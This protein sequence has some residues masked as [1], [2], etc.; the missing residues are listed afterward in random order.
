LAAPAMAGIALYRTRSLR[1]SLVWLGIAAGVGALWM[2]GH[3]L[4]RG[5]GMTLPFDAH[6]G[7]VPWRELG[8]VAG[9]G[10]TAQMIGENLPAPWAWG[11]AVGWV[12]WAAWMVVG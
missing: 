1:R 10:L 8:E 9:R 7:G 2:I 5:H 6:T 3:A 4:A 11:F 12:V